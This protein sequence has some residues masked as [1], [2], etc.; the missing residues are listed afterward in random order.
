MIQFEFD[1]MEQNIKIFNANGENQYK[2][3]LY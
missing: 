3:H 2:F 1:L